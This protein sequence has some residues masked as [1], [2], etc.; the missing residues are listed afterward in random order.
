M[1]E[2]DF[3]AHDPDGHLTAYSLR[4]TYAENLAVNLLNRPSSTLTPLTAAQVG[5]TYGEAL[6]QGATAP[7]WHGGTIRLTVDLSEAFPEPCCYQL[8]LRAWKR[9][10][11]GW[12]SGIIFGCRRNYAHRLLCSPAGGSPSG[13]PWRGERPPGPPSAIAVSRGDLAGS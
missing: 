6:E 4:A 7:T 5:P 10:V 1:L 8:E 3:M 9:T 2:I 13:R 11:V 12:Q